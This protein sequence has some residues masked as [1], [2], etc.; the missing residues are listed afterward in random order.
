MNTLVGASERLNVLIFLGAPGA[1]KGTVA[2]KCVQELGF[3][4]LSTGNLCRM[5]IADQTEV[6]KQIDLIIKS[7]KLVP[8]SLIVAMVADWFAKR[9]EDTSTIILDGFP[10]TVAQAEALKKLFE[11]E[12]PTVKLSVVK[13]EISDEAVVV[14][15]CSRVVC[16]NKAC[17][18]VYSL[19]EGSSL[20]PV[21]AGVC[22]LCG[23]GLIVRPDDA[24]DSVRKRLQVYHQH[25]NALL[26][27][28]GLIQQPVVHLNVER[29][30]DE[31]FSNFKNVIGLG[32]LD[33]RY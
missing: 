9:T 31:V 28:Y 11:K 17:Q 12:F 1:G 16:E 32:R 15:L 23:G 6:G 27:F 18:A 29:P 7:G 10:R 26:D 5:H 21:K 14:R 2:E 33:D 24:E 8:D 19:V 3:V 13:L 4:Q 25:E 20:V 30:L 22:D